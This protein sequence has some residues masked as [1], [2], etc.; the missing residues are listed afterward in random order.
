MTTTNVFKSE[1]QPDWG[2]GL[3]VE[4]GFDHW[5]LVFEHGGRKKFI[6]SKAKGLVPVTLDAKALSSLESKA[7]AK[8]KKP[9]LKPR[10]KKP[11]AA[12]KKSL[13]RFESLTQQVAFFEKLFPGGF[14]GE[15]FTATE[16]GLAGA[17]GKNAG[18]TA[19]IALAQAELSAERFANATPDELFESAKKV[20][21][22]TNI[23]FPIEGFIPFS[24]LSGESRTKAMEALRNLLHGQGEYGGRLERFAG[25]LDLKDKQGKAKVVTWPLATVF[26]ALFDPTKYCC[27]K[28]TPFTG[29]AAT[30]ALTD[31][32]KGQPV[33][34]R[35]YSQFLDVATKTQAALV[36]AGQKPRDLMDVYTFIWRTHAEKP[37]EKV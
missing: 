18:K 20:L 16:R 33:T 21:Q 9:G 26:G 35:G 5:V 15:G 12:K 34:A 8:H 32:E 19:A 1:L 36:A 37:A 29:Q 13:A 22:A 24:Q 3:V 27:V 14:E 4:D 30:L 17:T 6:K 10:E 25:S 23:V 2:L 28:P 31:V 7:H 11:S